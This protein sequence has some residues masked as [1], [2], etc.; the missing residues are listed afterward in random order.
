MLSFTSC[1]FFSSLAFDLHHHLNGVKDPDAGKDWRQRRRG[2]QRMRW[3]DA[4]TDSMDMNVSECGRQ[5]RTEEP[6]ELVLGVTKSRTWLSDWTTPPPISSVEFPQVTHNL[7]VIHFNDLFL[8]L[9]LKFP[10]DWNSLLL[11]FPRHQSL[12]LLCWVFSSLPLKC[13]W[14]PELHCLKH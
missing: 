5:Q 10:E 11:W 12:R 13:C 3:L 4:I 1:L 7:T 8:A 9:S 14:V 2:Q 6:G